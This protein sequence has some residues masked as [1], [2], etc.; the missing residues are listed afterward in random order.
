MTDLNSAREFEVKERRLQ[1]FSAGF[2]LSS[3]D[4]SFAW[5]FY[6]Y[7]TFSLQHIIQSHQKLLVLWNYHKH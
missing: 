4:D 2:T 5:G 7:F 6:F 1:T 3:V